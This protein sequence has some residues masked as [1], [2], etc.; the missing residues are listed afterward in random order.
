MKKIII[1]S[2]L[3]AM[4]YLSG[5][6]I[7]SRRALFYDRYTLAD[8]YIYRNENRRIQIEKIDSV[9]ELIM[10]F[11]AS[12]STLAAIDNY[13][14]KN[15]IAALVS[16]FCVDRHNAIQ[17]RFGTLRHQ[18]APLYRTTSSSNPERYVR[19]GTLVGIINN[20]S[21]DFTLIEISTING[22]WFVPK[23][24][25][26]QLSTD[27]FRKVI[28]VDRKFQ[29]I[30]ICEHSDSGWWLRAV[31]PATTGL[32]RA[33]YK[34]ATPLGIFLVQNK[35]RKMSFLKDGSSTIAGFSPY[36]SRFSGG[37]YIHGI[38]TNFPAQNIIE[39]SHSLGTTPRSHMC[40]RCATSLAKWIYDWADCDSTIVAVIE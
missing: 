4:F 12:N 30:A 15:G 29:N 1:F 37:A 3:G 9:I 40:V 19:D 16:D 18:S 35:L 14:N 11:S 33:P 21:T 22:R 25:I 24:Y 32:E 26:R 27:K 38:P 31:N 13:K 17:D 34:R 2:L 7:K 36:A 10:R 23:R 39:W 28:V 5:E 8:D 6:A 20:D